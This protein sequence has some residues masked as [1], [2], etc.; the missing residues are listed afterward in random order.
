MLSQSQVKQNIFKSVLCF[1][2]FT[3]MSVKKKVNL[4]AI[5]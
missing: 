4:K 3:G 2:L 1:P 5:Y